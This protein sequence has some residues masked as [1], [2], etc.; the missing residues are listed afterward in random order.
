MEATSPSFWKV[1]GTQLPLSRNYEGHSS[2]FPERMMAQLPLSRKN[3]ATSKGLQALGIVD[4]IG[5]DNGLSYYL[6]MVM[7]GKSWP[8]S[9]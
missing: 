9:Q 2:R 3:G 5:R 4:L 8:L 6:N 1:L 7:L